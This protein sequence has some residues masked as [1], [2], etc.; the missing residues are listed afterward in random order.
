MNDFLIQFGRGADPR[1]LAELLRARP[2]VAAHAAHCFEFPWGAAAVQPPRA[3]GYAPFYESGAL[4]ASVGRPRFLGV[5]HEAAGDRGFNRLLDER[6]RAGGAKAVSDALTG[7]FAAIECTRAGV[8]VLTDQMGFMPVYV[9][10]DAVGQVVA[11][12]THLDSVAAV[13]GRATDFDTVSLGDLLVNQY[14][15]FPYTTRR[16]VTQ[17]EPASVTEFPTPSTGAVRNADVR[18]TVLWEPAEPARGTK[19]SVEDLEA[20]LEHALREASQDVTR[21]VSRVA[22]TLSGGLDSR[23]VLAS[24]VPDKVAAAITYATRENREVEVARRV[25]AAAGVPHHVAWRGEEFYSDLLPRAVSLLGTELR[26]DCHGFCV[27][28][29]GLD[30]A[31]DLVVGG[32]LSDTLFKGHYITEATRERFRRRSIYSR[33][34]SVAGRA[35][36]AIG[37][38][39]PKA[40]KQHF[41]EAAKKMEAALTPEV[42][43]AVRERRAARLARVKAVRPLSAEEWGR[44]WPASRG[45]GAYGPQ[46]NTRLFTADELFM[47]RR[48]IEVAARVPTE[49][50]IGGRLS[51]R[52]FARLYGEL[53]RI[54]NSSTGLPAAADGATNGSA[55]RSANGQARPRPNGRPHPSP[56]GGSRAPW[57]DVEHSWVDWELLQKQSPTWASY[58]AALEP[59]VALDVLDG[60]LAGNARRFVASYQDDAGFLFNRAAVQ[61]AYAIDAA[62]RS[63]RPPA[64]PVP[65][66]P[67]PVPP[68]PASRYSFA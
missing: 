68:A 3:P 46:A 24:L 6:L 65:E 50:K 66:P 10:R 56:A 31:F 43:E 18:T 17:L 55:N 60:V 47:H 2:A 11:V 14:I 26:G 51:K 7:M 30:E 20:E 21:G 58:R 23:L 48:L 36:R 44:F 67:A 62:L 16:G 9:G 37:L 61:L 33:A 45:D 57:N 35:A 40:R 13:A 15:T 54:E 12:G 59:S 5:E 42:R 22:L 53:G 29:N 38:L 4:V 34:R 32:F 1:R 52:V 8:R 49:E 39:P 28:D 19:P 63:A 25:A 27:V 41:W 64:P